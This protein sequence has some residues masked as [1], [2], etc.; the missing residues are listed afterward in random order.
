MKQRALLFLLYA[1]LAL[2]LSAQQTSESFVAKGGGQQQMFL[3][4][5]NPRLTVT[6]Q[7]GEPVF[8]V[9]DLRNR[10][11]NGVT[12]CIFQVSDEPIS[13]ATPSI[14]NDAKDKPMKYIR[15]GM[16]YIE[17]NGVRYNAQ[18]QVIDK[19]EMDEIQ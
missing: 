10:V 18:G 1:G 14:A 5:D 12:T 13:T 2:S 17:R 8:T 7:N 6:I 9:R 16:L 19:K 3:L 4:E 11:M 15:N